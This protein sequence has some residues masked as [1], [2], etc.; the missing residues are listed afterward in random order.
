[1]SLVS[2]RTALHYKTASD[3]TRTRNACLEGRRFAINLH[4]LSPKH[5]S[6]SKRVTEG[7][8]R[9]HINGFGNRRSAIELP[10]RQKATHINPSLLPRQDLNL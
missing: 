3:E 6:M 10:R 8:T 5:S 7:R 2:Y 1:M 9:T 4:S